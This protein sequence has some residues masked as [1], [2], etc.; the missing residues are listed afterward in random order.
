MVPSLL[1]PVAVINESSGEEK[2]LMW[3]C[4]LWRREWD[5][6]CND[7]HDYLLVELYSLLWSFCCSTKEIQTL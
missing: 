6:E 4:F 3:C 2:L 1:H 5:Q 7:F